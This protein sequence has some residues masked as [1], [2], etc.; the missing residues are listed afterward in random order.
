MIAAPDITGSTDVMLFSIGFIMLF[1]GKMP[2]SK[3]TMAN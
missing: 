2:S 3:V 1:P